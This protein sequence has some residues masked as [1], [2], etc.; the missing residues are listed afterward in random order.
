MSEIAT[1]NIPLEK[2]MV[3]TAKNEDQEY[4]LIIEEVLG[5]DEV[6]VVDL[7]GEQHYMSKEDIHIN[8]LDWE[9][10][11]IRVFKVNNELVQKAKELDH[12]GNI[13]NY[14]S[15]FM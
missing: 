7:K 2:H 15:T 3:V 5:P 13:D 6:S 14:L 8:I 12:I 1:L 9:P 4:G 11:E 10:T